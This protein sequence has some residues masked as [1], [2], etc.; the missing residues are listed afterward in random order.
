MVSRIECMHI[1]F[2]LHVPFETPGFIESWAREKGHVVSFTCFF[3]GYA[4]PDPGKIDALVIMG[5]S[6]SVHDEL[7]F[8]WLHTE[9]QFIKKCLE[10]QKKLM[11]ICLGAQLIADVLGARVF[12]NKEKEIGFMPV[13]LT[14]A[15]IRDPLFAGLPQEFRVFH[16]HGE[17]FDLP[18]GAK[19]LAS[20][21]V[22]LNQAYRIGSN[23][24]GFQFHPEVTPQIVRDMVLYEGHELREAAPYIH[25]PERILNDLNGLNTNQSRMSGL[26]DRFFADR[27]AGYTWQV[28]NG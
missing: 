21:P 13:Q 22:C 12:D 14:Q 18:K 27:D 19:L 4:L 25:P 28:D 24:L 9:K 20:S 16:W 8:P 3:G 11:G 23:V 1:H 15:A 2:L 17:T 6:M 5:G 7:K 26:C 10:L